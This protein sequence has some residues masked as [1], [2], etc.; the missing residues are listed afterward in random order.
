MISIRAMTAGDLSHG[1]RLSTAAGWNQT[2]DDWRR[3][4]SIADGGCFAAELDGQ[5]VGTVA[6]CRF[7]DTA[8]IGLMLVDEQYRGRGFGKALM[9]HALDWLDARGIVCVRLDATPLGRPLYEKLGFE[10]QF[11]LARFGGAAAPAGGIHEE[12]FSLTAEDVRACHELDQLAIGGDRSRLLAELFRQGEALTARSGA[13][14]AG[15]VA[16]R[17]GARATFV[18]PCIAEHHTAGEQLLRAAMARLSGRTVMVDAPLG[19]PRAV[20]LLESA[21]L[22]QQR[23]FLRMA[24]GPCQVEKIE[25]L[26]ASSGPEKG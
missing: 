7:D 19:N 2:K 23:P 6:T 14:V 24:R 9:Q 11:E 5:V 17:P 20:N 13:A 4:L 15:Y 26:W 10:P 18:G 16:I 21:G 3:A 1:L 25:M 22:K 8:W 12:V